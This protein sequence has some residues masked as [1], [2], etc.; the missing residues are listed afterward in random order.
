MDNNVY[1]R[2]MPWNYVTTETFGCFSI[3]FGFF[4]VAALALAITGFF[5]PK[6]GTNTFQ[7][8]I[9]S[10]QEEITTL[11]E[12]AA[13][14]STIVC[15]ANCS[16]FIFIVGTLQATEIVT[17]ILNATII[18]TEILQSNNITTDTL[19]SIT[20]ES[21]ELFVDNIQS[22][23]TDANLQLSANGDGFVLVADDL[24]VQNFLTVENSFFVDS[25]FAMTV[26][27]SL[28]L[29]GNGAGVVECNDNLFIHG[30]L[31]IDKG[32]YIQ[33]PLV[34]SQVIIVGNEGAFLVETATATTAA[35]DSFTFSVLNTRILSNSL[36]F[37]TVT[38]YS[39]VMFTDGVPYV[40]CVVTPNIGTVTVYNIHATAA[41]NG[42]ILLQFL[43]V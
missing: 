31:N 28:E 20:I 42:E 4:L 34:T 22:F 18:T 3:L 5:F 16:D 40:T 36:V 9:D 30:S 11:D 19:Q 17:E 35:Q 41:F 37:V 25:I 10:L 33:S 15:T 39:G 24:L 21:N 43:I 2:R 38:D 1:R 8:Q 14:I 12:F 6:A 27:T 29:S 23:T 7:S 32:S 13:N 26:D